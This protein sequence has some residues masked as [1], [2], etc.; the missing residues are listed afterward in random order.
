MKFGHYSAAFCLLL[1]SAALSGLSADDHLMLPADQDSLTRLRAGEV[2]LQRGP[3]D[4]NGA[5]VSSL[6]FIRAPVERI[7]AIVT[8]C[9]MAKIWLAGLQFCAVLQERGKR[10]LTRQVVDQ[11]WAMPRLD[12]TFNVMRQPYRRMEFRLAQGNLKSMHGAWN[13]EAFPDGIMVRY[14]IALQPAVPSPR[15]LVRLIIQKDLPRM[16]RCIRGLSA[17]SGSEQ[18]IQKDL[19]RCPGEVPGT[20]GEADIRSKAGRAKDGQ[21]R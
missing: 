10:A 20:A 8:S 13:L 3:S 6:V 15:W 11:G 7:W 17:G 12:L 19:L 2:L 16:L 18:A 1:C 14:S 21:A 4:K 5:A 9:Q